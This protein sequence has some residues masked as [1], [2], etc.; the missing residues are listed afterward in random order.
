MDDKIS[1]DNLL[2]CDRGDKN[3]K[4]NDS[5]GSVVPKPKQIKI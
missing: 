1:I 5:H 4:F 2:S 3:L